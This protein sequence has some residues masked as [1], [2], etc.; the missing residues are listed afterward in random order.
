MIACEPYERRCSRLPSMPHPNT[1]LPKTPAPGAPAKKTQWTLPHLWIE[2]LPRSA[3]PRTEAAC[4]ETT[5]LEPPDSLFREPTS[6]QRPAQ[7][8]PSTLRA[9][10]Q[11]LDDNAEERSL[12]NRICWLSGDLKSTN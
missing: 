3:L 10:Q 11:A 2:G 9:D 7:Q 5:S 1:G 8:Q 4:V 6:R 12:S